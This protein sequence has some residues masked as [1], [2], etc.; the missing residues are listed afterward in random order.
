MGENNSI[1]M[2]RVFVV[3]LVLI[4]GNVLILTSIQKFHYDLPVEVIVYL[5]ITFIYFG[6]AVIR[7]ALR[8]KKIMNIG[9][10]LISWVVGVFWVRVNT[11]YVI[12]DQIF[13]EASSARILDLELW[14]GSRGKILLFLSNY[15]EDSFTRPVLINSQSAPVTLHELEVLFETALK[16][17]CKAYLRYSNFD[18][19]FR[20]IGVT[21]HI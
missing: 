2:A 9:I 11:P 1:R 5:H 4:F 6:G 7:R 20:P 17:P 3:C 13:I 14:K 16:R 19:C 8:W 12:C 18:V 21:I 10:V 15:E